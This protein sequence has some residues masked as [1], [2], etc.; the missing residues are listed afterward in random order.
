MRAAAAA[1]AAAQTNQPVPLTGPRVAL[2]PSVYDDSSAL[3]SPR[4]DPADQQPLISYNYGDIDM[5]EAD[6]GPTTN[7]VSTSFAFP[8]QQ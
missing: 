5:E 3:T 2:L 7:H 8:Q 4:A 1:D 6:S